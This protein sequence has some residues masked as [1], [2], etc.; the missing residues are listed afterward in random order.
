MRKPRCCC[1]AMAHQLWR[2]IPALLQPGSIEKPVLPSLAQSCPV[3]CSLG[4]ESL[5]L[6]SLARLSA[7]LLRRGRHD[8]RL[9]RAV[10]AE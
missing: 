1:L 7:V 9:R 2:S 5:E 6:L 4:L 10:Y 3:L 8:A